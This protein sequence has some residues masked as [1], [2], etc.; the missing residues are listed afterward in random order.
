MAREKSSKDKDSTNLLAADMISKTRITNGLSTVY[1]VC[2]CSFYVESI[3][4]SLK[5]KRTLIDR[6]HKICAS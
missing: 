5:K 3:N 2:V 1:T 4:S 6:D